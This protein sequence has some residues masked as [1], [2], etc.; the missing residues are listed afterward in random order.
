MIGVGGFL[1]IGEKNVGVPFRDIKISVRDNKEWLVLD[2]SK[3]DL[4]SAPAFSSA[5]ETSTSRG[6]PSVGRSVEASGER[7]VPATSEPKPAEP[8]P[9][10]PKA[11]DTA[12][13][14][15]DAA[16]AR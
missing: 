1:G 12:P 3:D 7:P 10:E 16:P 14:A 15:R 9:T 6:D 8:K 2:R 4:K 5:P 11:A 13:A